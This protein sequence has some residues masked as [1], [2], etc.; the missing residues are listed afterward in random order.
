MKKILLLISC[1]MV[2]L[3]NSCEKKLNQ[4]PLSSTTTLTF[5]TTSGDFVQASN[6]VYA[7]LRAYPDRLINLSETRSDNLYAVSDGGVTG[8]GK[9]LIVSI[10]HLPAMYTSMKHGQAILVEYT[11]PIHCLNNWIRMVR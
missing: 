11:K 1:S 6:A 7:S 8:I 2:V 5:Y 9:A 4:G 10:P 3:F